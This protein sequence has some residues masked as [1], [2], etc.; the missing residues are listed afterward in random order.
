MAGSGTDIARIFREIAGRLV[1]T[2]ELD[3]ALALTLSAVRQLFPDSILA[4]YRYWPTSDELE[5]VALEPE[6]GAHALLGMRL[7]ATVGT[8]LAVGQWRPAQV[9]RS[10]EAIHLPSVALSADA[11][12]HVDLLCAPIQ[13]IGRI[14]GVLQAVSE[15]PYTFREEDLANLHAIAALIALAEET[16]R[17]GQDLQTTTASQVNAE[18]IA[19]MSDMTAH[20]TH[21]LV[22]DMGAVRLTVQVL[23]R[24]HESGK[25]TDAELLEKLDGIERHSEGAIAL[26]RRIKRPFDRIES[27]PIQIELALDEVVRGLSLPDDVVLIRRVEP[28]LPPVYGTHQI[29]E[30]FHHLIRNA[31]DAM[32]DSPVKRLTLIGRRAGEDAVEV[33]VEDTGPGVPEPLRAGLFRLGVTGKQNALGY[34]LWWSKLYL[35][36]VGGA[37]ELDATASHGTRFVVRLAVAPTRAG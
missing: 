18:Y 13:G 26:V 6:T 34:G 5:V 14:L 7:P 15:R 25:L 36:R 3:T 27:A 1:A 35:T 29:T 17:R 11:S 2:P 24:Q 31:L 19:A 8:R 20:L 23:K 9:V 21:R 12:M 33:A 32:A 37:L 4:L 28:D 10:G 22:N 16:A 30:V